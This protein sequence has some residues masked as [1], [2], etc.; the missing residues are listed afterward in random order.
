MTQFSNATGHVLHSLAHS[1]DRR[2]REARHRRGIRQLHRLTPDQ[3]CDVGLTKEDL[4]VAENLPAQHDALRV[5]AD[6]RRAK[7]F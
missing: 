2:R 1:V 4:L 5:L 3:L 7:R 6:R